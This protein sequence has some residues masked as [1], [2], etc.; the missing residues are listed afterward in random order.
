MAEIKER[1]IKYLKISGISKKDFSEK[2][3]ISLW[4]ITGKS[5]KSE[6]GGEQ[7]S[8]IIG[9]YPN[10]SPDWLITG[11]GEMLRENGE[12]SEEGRGFVKIPTDVWETMQ[13]Q[14]ASLKAKDEQISRLI[15]MLSGNNGGGQ[16]VEA[17]VEG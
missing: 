3:G 12:K 11:K 14:T 4:N 2:T 8:L 1:L 6:L 9:N 7:I 17:N 5:V 10:I 15:E 16:P 13:M